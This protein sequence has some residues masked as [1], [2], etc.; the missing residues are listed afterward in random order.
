[1]IGLPLAPSYLSGIPTPQQP[2]LTTVPPIRQQLNHS[3]HEARLSI[4]L[5]CRD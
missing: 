4:E 5:H 3:G 2:V 1:M